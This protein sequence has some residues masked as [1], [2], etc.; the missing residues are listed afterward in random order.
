MSRKSPCTF[1]AGEKLEKHR[2]V[3]IDTSATTAQP[4]KIIYSDENEV[5]IGITEFSA[6]TGDLVAVAMKT[7]ERTFDVE[8]I[9]GSAIAVGTDLYT[10]DDGK[11]SDATNAGSAE[12]VALQ[13]SS[14]SGDHIEVAVL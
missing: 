3:K 10:K 12:A 13:V 1:V 6:P 11:F 2:R 9:V 5:W 4:A 7:R 14:A 8:V